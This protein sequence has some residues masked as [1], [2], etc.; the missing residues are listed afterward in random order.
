MA[1]TYSCANALL[2]TMCGKRT[3]IPYQN[4]YIGLST[5]APTRSGT[6]YTEPTAASYKRQRFGSASTPAFNKMGAAANGV[7]KNN[8]TGNEYGGKVFFPELQAGES[9]GEITHVLLFDSLTS[10]T[11]LAYAALETSITPTAGAIPVI[12]VES[13]TLSLE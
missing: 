12:P 13:I 9:Y 3:T 10:G 5:T 1:T 11:L 4:T 8:N 2:E 6:G 7:I